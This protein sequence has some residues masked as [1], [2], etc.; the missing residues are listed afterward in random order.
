MGTGYSNEI[1]FVID[2]SVEEDIGTNRTEILRK[3]LEL[4]CAKYGVDLWEKDPY[5]DD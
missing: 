4:V 1:K 5:P 3:E 2:G